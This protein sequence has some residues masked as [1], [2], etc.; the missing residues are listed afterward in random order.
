VRR[1]AVVTWLPARVW[2]DG[3]IVPVDEPHLLV[4]DR[5]FQLG[6]GLFETLRARRGVLI[7][8]DEHRVRLREGAEA[9]TIRLPADDVLAHGIRS[10]LDVEHLS[11]PGDDRLAPGDASVRITVSR[12][13]LERRGTLPPGWER[14][15]PTIVIQV[16]GHTPAP[17]RLVQDGI[18]AISSAVRRDPGSPLAGLKAT[19]RADHVYA[20][21]EAERARADDALFLTLD[22]RIAESTSANVFAV[23]GAELLTPTLGSA[24]LPGTTRTW[25]LR[26][27]GVRALGLTASEVDLTPDQLVAADEAFLCASVT[28][29]VPLVELDGRPIGD[30][31]PG[32]LTSRLRDAREAWIDGASLI[33]SG[34]GV[35]N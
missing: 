20:K 10:L 28:G 26:D 7:E 34:H 16:W 14:T 18:R 31:R 8:W 21:L 6:D 23:H 32:P 33:G 30:G 1:L 17:A 11:G 29:V 9:L 22:G 15:D 4:T 24:I 2:V 12:G 25:L 13:P 35:G 19:S 5:G 3:R 27:P